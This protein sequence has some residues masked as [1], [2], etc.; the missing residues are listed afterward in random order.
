M[1]RKTSYYSLLANSISAGLSVPTDSL[2]GQVASAASPAVANQIGQYFKGLAADN[3]NGQLNAGQE[4]AHVLAHGILA[5]AVASAGGNDATTAGIAAAGSE[6][7]APAVAKWLYGTDDPEKLNANQKQTIISIMGAA[8]TTVG[9]TTGNINN[10]IAAGQAGQNAVENNYL[11]YNEKSTQLQ[12][13]NKWR[14]CVGSGGCSEEELQNL[15]QQVKKMD[16]LDKLRDQIVFDL[17]KQGSRAD[18]NTG[19]NIASSVMSDYPD[20]LKKGFHRATEQEIHDAGGE[21]NYNQLSSEFSDTRSQLN[22]AMAHGLDQT[23]QMTEGFLDGP[24]EA[25]FITLGLGG[26]KLASKAVSVGS[27]M[28]SPATALLFTKGLNG[29]LSG[30]TGAY[31]S[32]DDSSAEDRVKSVAFGFGAGT[33]TSLVFRREPTAINTFLLGAG[34]NVAGQIVSN[35]LKD[36]GANLFEIDPYVAIFSGL[37]NVGGHK[38][39]NAVGSQIYVKPADILKSPIGKPLPLSNVGTTAS[40]VLQ[41]IIVGGTDKISNNMKEKDKE[42]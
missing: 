42:K 6:A 17:C 21:D 18:C 16:D 24:K 23:G 11:S 27:E 9:S 20:Y 8:S 22:Q 28:V 19:I 2:A 41:G 5:A 26:V 34:S 15:E 40:S 35:S 1:S 36:D 38:I 12:L 29:G 10:A 4:T 33:A 3:Q 14:K 25:A 31:I 37:A 7:A 30:A 32:S 13:V 39:G